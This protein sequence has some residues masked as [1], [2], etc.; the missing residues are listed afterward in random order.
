TSTEAF[1][2][3]GCLSGCAMVT[4]EP[5]ICT[6]TIPTMPIAAIKSPSVT[7]YEAT[8]NSGINTN[9]LN[10]RL[11]KKNSVTK[12]EDHMQGGKPSS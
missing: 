6:C 8:Q 2:A 10:R 5:T 1:E 11:S 3:G 9:T 4:S 7:R 12:A